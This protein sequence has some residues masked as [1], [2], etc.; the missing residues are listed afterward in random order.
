MTAFAFAAIVVLNLVAGLA[1]D[2]RAQ[3]ASAIHPATIAIEIP[4]RANWR[5]GGYV[6]EFDIH[7]DTVTLRY[8]TRGGVSHTIASGML[9]PVAQRRIRRGLPTIPIPAGADPGVPLHLTLTTE[10][11][12]P[13]IRIL[14]REQM[15]AEDISRRTDLDF[16]LLLFAGLFI[17]LAFANL[18][19][20]ASF[21]DRAYVAYAGVMLSATV[22]ALRSSPDIFWAW[23]FPHISVRYVVVHDA[24]ILAYAVCLVAFTRG[25]LGTRKILPRYDRL[26]VAMFVLFFVTELVVHNGFSSVQ[27]RGTEL[28]DAIYILFLL[29]PFLGG[30]LAL[31]AG[32]YAARYYLIACAGVFVSLILM[33]LL[34][35]LGYENELIVFLGIAWE[36][37]WL[38]AALGDRVRR[39]DKA[40][41]DLANEQATAALHDSLTGLAN[42]RKIESDLRESAAPFSLLYL[43]IDHFSLVNAAAGHD[44]GDR[45]LASIAALLDQFVRAGETLAR[46]ASD[47]FAFLLKRRTADDIEQTAN[48]CV[49]AIA[50]EPFLCDNQMFPLTV[51]A[52]CL[53]VTAPATPST[54]LAMAYDACA[55]AKEKGRNRVYFATDDVAQETTRASIQWA[56]RTTAALQEDRFALFY[57]R[58]VPLRETTE[59]AHIEILVR[60]VDEDGT[61]VESSQFLPAAD[62][63]GLTAGVDRWVLHH[64]LIA[65]APM[66]R[67][68]RLG[69]VS[70]NLSG[71][72]LQDPQLADF[73]ANE[74]RESGM[75]PSALC[76]EITETVV[77]SMLAE[78]GQL[79]S[80]LRR[81]GVCFS[82]DDFGTGTSSL[83]VLRELDVDYLKIDGAFVRDC[84][85]NPVDAAM[86]KTIR[87]LAHALGLKTIAEYARDFA[88]VQTLREIGIDYAQGW[89]FAKAQPLDGATSSR[90]LAG[91]ALD[92]LQQESTI[93]E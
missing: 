71:N 25:F 30:V 31:R 34:A 3:N 47:E 7:V 8:R 55:C 84:A 50:R 18:T 56:R 19:L 82:L 36:G 12:N 61:I 79:I 81:L 58:I 38:I 28:V 85:T 65:V 80:A 6:I 40:A 68:G 60:L 66:V 74:I 14:S 52:G 32:S 10:I 59:A 1:L 77:L 62:R 57:Q 48:D 83:G 89:A 51:S 91:T 67:A 4:Y 78:V 16:P 64:S 86:L 70:I 72:A 33:D 41:L 69:S 27:F 43:D 20:F 90:A 42:R 23:L 39:L 45:I 22:I 13:A 5:S 53:R 15:R 76:L 75:K 46:T 88:I 49:S 63:Y 26:L 2:A 54:L 9:V 29:V 44:A 17:A 37:L 21:R 87:D 11:N 92:F 93:R 73:I 35:I 24:S